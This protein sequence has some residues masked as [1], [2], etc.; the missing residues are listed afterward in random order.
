MTFKT[1]TLQIDG[2]IGRLSL[3]RPEKRNAINESMLGEIASAFMGGLDGVAALIL[4]AEG[5]T[6]CAG[7]DLAEHA[8][9]S[10][11]QAMATSARWHRVVETISRGPPPVIAALKGHVIGG[12]LE[13]AAAA[14]IRIAE[15]DCKFALP[16]GRHGIFVGGGAS[17]TVGRLIGASRM[18]EMMLTGRVVDAEEAVRIGLVHHVVP[19]GAALDRAREIAETVAQNAPLSNLMMLQALPR[20]A[21]MAPAEGM[22]TESLAVALTQSSGEAAERMRRFLDKRHA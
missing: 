8:V 14:H 3:A 6:F 9:R 20:I 15:A 17:V 5:A 10:P 21:E 19:V 12:G 18:M 16:E 1:I 13:I 22:F 11:E 7:L 2:R 4:D